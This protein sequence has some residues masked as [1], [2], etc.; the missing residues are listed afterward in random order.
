MS[1]ADEARDLGRGPGGTCG[2]LK[3]LATLGPTEQAEVTEA[4]A[5]RTISAARLS[6]AIQR[7]GWAYV[8]DQTITRHRQEVCRCE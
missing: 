4:I 5:D 7:R 1:L 8:S 2:V 6:K 3:L